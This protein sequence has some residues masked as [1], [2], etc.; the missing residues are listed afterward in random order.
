MSHDIPRQAFLV[1][2][3]G[4]PYPAGT[5]FGL[6]RGST[7]IGRRSSDSNPDIAF[8]SLCVSRRHLVI[9]WRDG[10]Y[11]AADR[12]SKNGTRI[13]GAALEEGLAARIRDGD[14]LSLAADAVIFAFT[15]QVD[16]G[17]LSA[18]GADG[19]RRTDIGLDDERREIAIDGR[20]LRL[21]GNLYAL[22]RVLY[23][24]RGRAVSNAEIRASVWPD[25][26]KDELGVPNAA[27]VEI[28]TLVMRLRKRLEDYGGLVCNLRG[29]GY[30]LDIK[31]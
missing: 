4:E 10:S 18:R 2:V 12:G 20:A 30:M 21:S 22:F 16:S 14:R 28:N 24:N 5:R 1:V 17:T 13:N 9:E 23:L 7:T 19:D 11:F 25:R 3:R 29:Y 8:D 6:G 27:D 31:E 26:A 15:T